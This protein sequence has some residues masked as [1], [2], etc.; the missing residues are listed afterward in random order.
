MSESKIAPPKTNFRAM[1]VR[2]LIV[3]VILY[4]ASF[5]AFLSINPGVGEGENLPHDS[6]RYQFGVWLDCSGVDSLILIICAWP[7]IFLQVF[8]IYHS[9]FVPFVC[10]PLLAGVGWVFLLHLIRLAILWKPK[11]YP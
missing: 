7:V 1:I 6:F 5:I 4:L 9:D 10:F 8:G 11:N 3:G 2:G